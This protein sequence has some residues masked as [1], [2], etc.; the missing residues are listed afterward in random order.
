MPR[1]RNSVNELLSF[2]DF[3]Q[4]CAGGGSVSNSGLRTE[5]PG[6][7]FELTHISD[8]LFWQDARVWLSP[9]DAIRFLSRVDRDS[10]KL[11]DGIRR[12]FQSA[13]NYLIEREEGGVLPAMEVLVR[14]WKEFSL[15]SQE[16]EKIEELSLDL[17]ETN[18]TR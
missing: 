10:F 15:D 18:I 13:T 12:H 17:I 1:K 3:I 7:Q 5:P 8:N 4:Y 9:E 11:K 6:W 16:Q 2:E 14:V